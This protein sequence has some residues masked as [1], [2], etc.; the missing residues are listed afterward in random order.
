MRQLS[1]SAIDG[2][3]KI[4][5]DLRPTMLDQLGLVAALR[6]FAETRLGDVGAYVEVTESGTV[7]R[8]PS[9]LET[10]LF[11]TVQ[12]AIS[13]IARHAG[14]R[15]VRIA[16]HFGEEH[17]EIGVEDD[18]IGFDLAEITALRDPRCGLGLVSMYERMSAVGGEFSLTSARGQGTSIRL[19]APITG[20]HNGADSSSGRG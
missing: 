15:H 7:R 2:V 19:R 8:V 16:F 9:S 12:E 10:A 3:H 14:A 17:I 5:F 4:I 13:N 20:G 11:R 6:S 18:G 1:V